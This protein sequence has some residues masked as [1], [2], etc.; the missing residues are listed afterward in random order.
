MRGEGK[1]FRLFWVALWCVCVCARDW[2]IEG[3]HTSN[4]DLQK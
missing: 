2:S 1:K 3:N 4:T